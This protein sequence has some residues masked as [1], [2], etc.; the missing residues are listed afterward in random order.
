MEKKQT[1]R[2]SDSELE[3]I[4]SIFSENDAI[5]IA[6]RK[7]FLQFPLSVD[8]SKLILNNFFGKDEV[9]KVLR[10]AYLP[11][12]DPDAPLH[13]LIDLW[14]TV[15]IK[16]KE[17][18]KAINQLVARDIVIKYLDQQLNLL[19]NPQSKIDIKLSS[20]IEI[21]EA[22]ETYSNFIARN[23]IIQHTEMQ[24]SMLNTLAGYKEETLENTKARLLK[25]S[26]K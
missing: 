9:I 15:D 1:M 18:E 22:R 11:E 24:L 16:D 25:D 17:P 14:M 6:L 2:F 12:L 3:I 20:L 26:S 7:V 8:E 19:A 5:L 10:K 23:T 21:G 4:K 13:Q